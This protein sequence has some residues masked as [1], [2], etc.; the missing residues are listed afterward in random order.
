M[1][2]APIGRRMALVWAPFLA[3]LLTARSRRVGE[4]E[5]IGTRRLNQ[6]PDVLHGPL[7]VVMQSGSFGAPL[8]TGGAAMIS[9]RPTLG[10]RLAMS[11][12][13][14]Y[15]LAKGVKHLVR[16]GRPLEL[17]PGVR[18]R[19]QPASGDGFVSGHAAVSMALATEAL[20]FCGPALW[21]L[22]VV[23]APVVGLSRVYVGAHL[24]LDVVGGAAL[25]WAVSRT[26]A[27]TRSH[28]ASFSASPLLSKHTVSTA[29]VS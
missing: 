8:V 2:G 4:W 14:A 25:G 24:P 27:A 5:H 9:G 15:F 19:G 1:T 28:A 29:R 20:E 11:G 16:R 6:L 18:I 10:R 7:W 23:I 17:S 22:P 21:P 13:T 3:A 12:L 26:A